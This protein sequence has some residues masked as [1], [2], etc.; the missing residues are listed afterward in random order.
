MQRPH[1]GVE[2]GEELVRHQHLAAV[3]ARIRVDLPALV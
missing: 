1:R 2:R 3:S